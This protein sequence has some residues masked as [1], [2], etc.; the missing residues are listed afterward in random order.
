LLHSGDTI[1][2]DH[3]D[4]AASV[5]GVV[6]ADRSEAVYAYAKL[7]TSADVIPAPLCLPGLDA[8]R[9]YTVTVS[10]E[11][12]TPAGIGRCQPDW[13]RSGTVTAPGSVL[14]TI[15]LPAPL[16]HPAHAVLL[17]VRGALV[18]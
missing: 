17:E 12:E 4:P 15:G 10:E 14:T 11:M 6:A 3:P 5:H 2:A 9:W 16:I 8:E 7:A 18:S 13:L 1:Y